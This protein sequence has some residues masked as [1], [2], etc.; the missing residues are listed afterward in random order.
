MNSNRSSN[1]GP[2]QPKGKNQSQS[3]KVQPRT[4]GRNAPKNGGGNGKP[5]QAAAAAAYATGN[6]GKAPTITMSRDTCR[7]VHREL[8]DSVVGTVAFTVAKTLALNPGLAASFPWLS[9]MAQGWEQY[10]FRKL[11][12]CYYTRTGSNVPGSVMLAPDYDAAD[13]APASEQ[14]ASAF[15]DVAEDAPWKDIDCTLT[16]LS[17]AGGQSRKF[18]RSGALAA[19]LD[20]KSYD[21]GN[22]HVCTVDGTAVNWGKLW[23]EYDIDF[24]VPQLPPTGQLALVGG[25]FTG[26]TA[27][28]AANPF[29]T[30]PTADAQNAGLTMSAASVLTFGSAGTFVVG[31]RYIG[32]VIT[33]IPNPTAASGATI[34]SGGADFSAAATSATQEIGVNVTAPGATLAFSLTATTITSAIVQVGSAPSGSLN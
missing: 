14:I 5:K 11:K 15:Q 16:Q 26:A 2:R 1:Q 12:Y 28:T 20:V 6:V 8:V 29:G 32:T 7:I 3:K 34:V 19:N 21:S 31:V 13:A 22:M 24:F 25:Q 17:M 27:Q 10:R 23:V 33:A 9:V 30:A 4:N 18:T